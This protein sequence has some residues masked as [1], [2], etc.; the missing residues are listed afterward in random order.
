M[1]LS[2]STRPLVRHAHP[3]RLGVPPGLPKTARAIQ[4]SRF[5][6]HLASDLGVI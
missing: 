1:I 6:V 5:G 3:V 4:R 2:G